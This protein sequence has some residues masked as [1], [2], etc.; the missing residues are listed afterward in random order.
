MGVYSTL[1]FGYSLLKPGMSAARRSAS[2]REPNSAIRKVPWVDALAGAAAAGAAAAPAVA[3]GLA[4]EPPGA[5]AARSETP[6]AAESELEK[7]A[8]MQVLTR[9]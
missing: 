8:A 7:P 9:R 4:V 3:A 5:Q 6:G 2:E 1:T